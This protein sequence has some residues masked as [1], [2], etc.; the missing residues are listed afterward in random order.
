[1]NPKWY[2][3]SI[4]LFL[5]L[6]STGNATTE[7]L[8]P[9]SAFPSVTDSIGEFSAES[10][11]ISQAFG[12]EEQLTTDSLYREYPKTDG[13]HI[14]WV[15]W[16]VASK[17][18]YYDIASGS[19][20]LISNTGTNQNYPE[21]HSGIAV[22]QE[23]G[24]KKSIMSASLSPHVETRTVYTSDTTAIKP[25]VYGDRV[26]WEE[27][28][29][30]DYTNIYYKRIGDSSAA[31]LSR[32]Q[33]QQSNP[34]IYGDYVVWQELDSGNDGWN[35][36]LFNLQTGEKKQLT[37][38]RAAQINPDISENLVVWE[39]HRDGLSNIMVHDIERDVTTAVTFDGVSNVL[40][41]VSKNI[42]VWSRMGNNGYDIYM[43]NLAGP[44]T[45]VVAQA[46][47]DQLYADI[48]T[49]IIVWQDTRSGGSNIFYYKLEPE[50]KFIPYLFFGSATINFQ[51]APVDS[52]IEARI[53]G[54]ARGTITVTSA[55]Q[56]GS[57]SQT[58]GT[59]L[60]V[61][62]TQQ[63]LGKSI[64]FW[65]DGTE[66]L[67]RL[68][69]SGS[70]GL[71]EWPL[72]FTHAGRFGEVILRGTAR[73]NGMAA[74]VGT[75]ISASIDGVARS[76]YTITE[77]GHYGSLFPGALEFLIPITELDLGKAIT[78][79]LGDIRADQSFF[80]QTSGTFTLDL[81]G[82]TQPVPTP[83]FTP[84]HPIP[85][86]TP[87]PAPTWTPQPTQG[88]VAYIDAS[89]R[90]GT[91]PLTVQ[92]VDLSVG[93]PTLWVWSFGDGS[94]ESLES[95]PAHTFTNPGTYTVTLEIANSQSYDIITIPQYITVLGQPV[96]TPPLTPH[97][98]PS[99]APGPIPL[100]A[101]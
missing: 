69:I 46:A 51:P 35:I 27:Y 94:P 49:D 26:V 64:T 50:T 88:L 25:A 100:D 74:P 84:P 80:V 61:P 28:A 85:T 8:T 20:N 3:F 33:N 14:I 19:H 31:P 22:W 97:P 89:P 96:P 92:F 41:A 81:T 15:E 21:I 2:V 63:D 62:I 24:E 47:G 34:R 40:P 90:S 10:V 52:V 77:A 73:V 9:I 98:T 13:T 101:S 93:G 48:E 59:Q 29:G 4:L 71:V 99:P 82:T 1:M 11:V 87:Q 86:W 56:Y 7:D 37:R 57:N 70:G 75:I 16:N 43:V 17:I 83:T 67:P 6:V 65:C 12:F 58:F 42:I 79:S 54:V 45:Y 78:F 72:E 53:D 60:T 95:Y 76:Q 66:G 5:C 18:W 38:D 39:D 55:G 23:I 68:Q 30:N 36:Y 32:S 44:T 91:A